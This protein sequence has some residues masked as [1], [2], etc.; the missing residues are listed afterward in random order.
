MPTLFDQV[1]TNAGQA[2]LGPA[3]VIDHVAAVVTARGGL[4]RAPDIG[5]SDHI[6]RAGWVA[7]GAELDADGTMP[8]Q[9]YWQSV[10][11]LDFDGSCFD[12]APDSMPVT[13]IRWF[14]SPGTQAHLFVGGA[15]PVVPNPNA[16]LA[17]YDRGLT[18]WTRQAIT[19]AG[20]LGSMTTLWTYTVPAGFILAVAQAK[21]SWQRQFV[22]TSPGQHHLLLNVAGQSVCYLLSRSNT[23]NL[24]EDELDGGTIYLPTGTV[25]EAK[26]LVSETGIDVLML[27]SATGYL[28]SV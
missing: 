15:V 22:A 23:L 11:W 3:A 5:A 18:A 27:A 2:A 24:E 7:L 10:Q 17:P 9:V 13:H 28:F 8:H 19:G 6:I 16:S 26:Y 25:I 21:V 20:T 14:L 12:P 4:V 1:V